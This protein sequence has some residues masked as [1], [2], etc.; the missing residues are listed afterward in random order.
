MLYINIYSS[1]VVSLNIDVYSWYEVQTRMNFQ[2]TIISFLHASLSRPLA[3]LK[4]LIHTTYR[5][6]LT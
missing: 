6:V 1:C 2:A 4:H 5:G 3:F